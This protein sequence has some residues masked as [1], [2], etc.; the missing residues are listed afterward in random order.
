LIVTVLFKIQ[1]CL[2][3][4]ATLIHSHQLKNPG[5]QAVR[6]IGFKR[7][8]ATQ[9]SALGES[10]PRSYLICSGEQCDGSR[11]TAGRLGEG[12]LPFV[13]RLRGHPLLRRLLPCRPFP[14]RPIRLHGCI[15]FSA[16]LYTILVVCILFSAMLDPAVSLLIIRNRVHMR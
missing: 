8:A 5:K 14:P 13:R 10:S 2:H 11:S 9:L 15:P 6:Y 3:R 12:K 1:V 4:L 7:S 16:H